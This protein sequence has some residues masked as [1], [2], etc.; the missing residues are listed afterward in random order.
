M[1]HDFLDEIARPFRA[2]RHR[3]NR[4]RQPLTPAAQRFAPGNAALTAA[5]E[6]YAERTVIYRCGCTCVFFAGG[7]HAFACCPQ[8]RQ[9]RDLR[10]WEAELAGEGRR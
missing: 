10:L 5:R 8:R 3:R 7:R 1:T 9:H 6:Q 2:L 4:K